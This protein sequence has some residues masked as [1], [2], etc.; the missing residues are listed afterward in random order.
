[1]PLAAARPALASSVSDHRAD[2]FHSPAGHL[3]FHQQRADHLVRAGPRNPSSALTRPAQ[4]TD[5]S[6]LET[7]PRARRL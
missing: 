7:V 5:Y 1:V 2:P 3:P 6:V 4:R